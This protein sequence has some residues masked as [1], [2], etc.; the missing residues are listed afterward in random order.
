MRIE[1]VED[2]AGGT[3]VITPEGNEQV[4]IADKREAAEPQAL[5]GMENATEEAKA[6]QFATR[7]APTLHA[8][9][10]RKLPL[11][12][13]NIER[14]MVI[15]WCEQEYVAIE[16]WATAKQSNV[17]SAAIS[18]WQNLLRDPD[19]LF[20]ALRKAARAKELAENMDALEAQQLEADA[21]DMGELD[22]YRQQGG[23]YR[24]RVAKG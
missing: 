24:G 13:R 15:A 6:V 18:F 9:V 12:A 11:Q 5:P 14:H 2:G 22:R 10:D 19:E 20:T 8:M 4:C 1:Y 3:Y 17:K 7:L 23:G 16:A 21:V